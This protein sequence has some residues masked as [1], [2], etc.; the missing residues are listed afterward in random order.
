MDFDAVVI[1]A[2]AAGLAAARELRAAG[3]RFVVLEARGRAGGRAWTARPAGAMVELGAEFVHGRPAATTA[4][5]R[6]AGLR[7]EPLRE[8][9]GARADDWSAVEKAFARLDPKARDRSFASA[10]KTMS[11]VTE[12]EADQARKFVEGFHA[13][14]TRIIGV[15]EL[16]AEGTQGAAR[17]SRVREGYGALWEEMAAEAPIVLSAPVRELRW[18][19]AGVRVVFGSGR[20][21]RR[22]LTART[23]VVSLPVGVLKARGGEGSVRF[24]PPLPA[25]KRAALERLR[26]GDVCKVGLLFKPRAWAPVGRALGDGFLRAPGGR[27]GVYWTANPLPTPLATAWSGGPPARALLRLGARGAA[28]EAVRGLALALGMDARRLGAGLRGTFFHDWTADPFSRGA[29]SYAAAG[30][31]GAR[32]A[33]AEPVSGTLFFAGEAC[34][35]RGESGT[36]GGAL[37]S[38]ARAGRLAAASA[39]RRRI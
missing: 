12:A 17:S 21:A 20:G 5:L 33:L 2:G 15:K 27:F 35:V 9:R 28:R 37:D 18:S 10:L 19:R 7:A 32:A 1:G 6:R 8:P 31:A 3:L 14:D 39:R 29:Y 30:G 13:A 23:A 4:A 16:A 22:E 38:G 26:M 25:A 34:D 11:G 36:V 24:V